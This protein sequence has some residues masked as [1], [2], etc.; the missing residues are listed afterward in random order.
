MRS[1]ISVDDASGT[2]AQVVLHTTEDSRGYL[3]SLECLVRQWS[4]CSAVIALSRPLRFRRMTS[5]VLLSPCAT[6]TLNVHEVHHRQLSDKVIQTCQFQ[7]DQSV[8][9]DYSSS[10]SS[11]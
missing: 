10:A 2:V 8:A 5:P 4:D 3:V 6:I 9:L 11:E 1:L 7:G